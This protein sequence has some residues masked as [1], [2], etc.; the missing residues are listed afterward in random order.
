MARRQFLWIDPRGA[1]C[2]FAAPGNIEYSSGEKGTLA[3]WQHTPSTDRYGANDKFWRLFIDDD[4]SID[5]RNGRW[6]R[7]R[8]AGSTKMVGPTDYIW[9]QYGGHGYVWELMVYT[10]DFTGEAG[11]GVLRAYWDGVE[12][13]GAIVDATAPVGTAAR[14]YLGPVVTDPDTCYED[15]FCIDSLAVWDDLMTAE[16]VTELYG[17]THRYR[18][19]EDDGTGNLLLLATFDGHYDADFAAGSPTF[20]CADDE[21]YCLLDDGAR[22]LGRRRFLLGQ[23]RHDFSEDDRVPL[24]AALVVTWG[25][26][27]ADYLTVTNHENYAQLEVAAGY[28]Q[29]RPVG[30][31]LPGPPIH[32]GTLALWNSALTSPATYRQRI[33]IPNDTNKPQTFIRIGPV[34]YF[35]SPLKVADLYDQYGSGHI[36]IVVAD[37]G[38]STTQFKT[39]LS[40]DYENDYW[41]GAEVTFLTGDCAGRRLKATDYA[42]ATKI[43]AMEGALPAIPAPGD[44][45]LV[46]FRA[47]I[48]GTWSGTNTEWGK[49]LP[50]MTMDA[51]LWDSYGGSQYFTELEWCFY[52]IW[53]ESNMGVINLLR[54]ERGRTAYMDGSPGDAYGQALVYGRP[55]NWQFDSTFYC[56]ILLE[57]IEV[58]SPSLYQVL[59]RDASGHGP[60]YADNFMLAEPLGE[61]TKVWRKRNVTRTKQKPTKISNPALPKADLQAANTW[62]HAVVSPPVAV[63]YDE[64]TEAVTVLVKG[65]SSTGTVKYGYCVGTWN[66]GTGRISW[67]DETPPGG[68]ANPFLNETDLLPEKASDAMC[69]GSNITSVHEADDGWYLVY[70]SQQAN[71]DHYQTFLWGPCSDRWSFSR[72]DHWWDGNPLMS[73]LGGPDRF[74]P[75][76]S[77]AGHWLNRG[78]EFYVVDNPYTKDPSRRYWGWAQG[79]TINHRWRNYGADSRPLVGMRGADLRSM[80]PLPHGNQVTPLVGIQV[81]QNASYV[82]GQ[83]DCF[84]QYSDTAIGASSGVYCYVSEDGVHWQTYADYSDWLPML[85]LDG[86]SNRLMPGHPFRLGDRTI[87]YYTGGVLNFAWCRVHGECW[88]ALDSGETDGLL[89]TPL[90]EKPAE[91]WGPLVCSCDPN[92]GA[93]TVEVLDATETVVAGYAEADCDVLTDATEQSVTWKGVSLEDLDTEYIRIRFGF[94][95]SD[96]MGLPKLYQWRI[97]DLVTPAVST[98]RIGYPE[99]FPFHE[100]TTSD[101]KAYP[102]PFPG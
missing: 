91:G 8:S 31:V 35:H 83:S 81:H 84:M 74:A 55:A 66:A 48:Q 68:C 38:N 44:V 37:D 39:D 16:Q 59:K 57:R 17:Q 70:V 26:D 97:E 82:Y 43:L 98:E 27:R 3:I 71:V 96:E 10:W 79:K 20:A 89:E 5:Q 30:A 95:G 51:W 13:D 88:Y 1:D 52:G 92:G 102:D 46:D 75:E 40:D 7:L 18:M 61:S 78:L 34:D 100:S 99:E 49:R 64:V 72:Q 41:N 4:N 101:K 11:Y 60:A 22:E 14:L 93:V 23:P 80:M 29:D 2:Y 56:D 73:M 69:S 94:S 32:T 15:K 90:I 54:Y 47:V 12:S 50:E 67:V 6:L 9:A 45:G 85:E 65:A 53:N 76:G 86:E 77:G 19:G 87:Y 21:R 25:N 62:R 33:H 42:S 24:A 28:D 63:A 58:D 36:F